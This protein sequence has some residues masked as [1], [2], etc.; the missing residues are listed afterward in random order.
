MYSC[1]NAL[2]RAMAV[3]ILR[4]A[5]RTYLRKTSVTTKM[6]GKHGECVE[7]QP[8]VDG[9]QQDGHHR[10]QEKIVDHGHDAGREQVV[11]RV[12]V[13]GDAR[14]QPAHGIPVEIAHRQAL[15]APED[16][17]A[18]VV[19]GLLADALHDA[20]LDVL[21]QKIEDQHAAGKSR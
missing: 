9:K 20:D 10:Q 19:H 11:Q 3:R 2:I 4:F 5:S 15:Q 16:L 6:N 14:H 17:R 7:C 12:H 13:G 21:R 1:K 18:H 8:G